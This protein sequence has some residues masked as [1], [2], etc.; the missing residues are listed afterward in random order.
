[1]VLRESRT[2]RRCF[3]HLGGLVETVMA[4]WT[5]HIVLPETAL[6]QDD[7]DG[8]SNSKYGKTLR[9][10]SHRHRQIGLVRLPVQPFLVLRNDE[11]VSLSG[12]APPPMQFSCR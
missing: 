3:E 8:L 5:V 12:L 4:A 2:P 6:R 10:G 1:M 9:S 7:V 11:V